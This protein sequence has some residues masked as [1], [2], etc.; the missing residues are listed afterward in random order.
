MH[1]ENS[2][3]L[4]TENGMG[5]S[6]VMN[7]ISSSM[8]LIALLG[9]IIFFGIMNKNFFAANNFI[10]IGQTLSV[11]GVI[12]IGQ[13][14]CLLTGGFD[15]SVG[16]L[17]SF[18][19]MVLASLI[20]YTEIPYALGVILVLG[21]GLGCGLVHGLVITKLKVNA[22]ITTLGFMTI[23]QGLV[24]VVSKG[25]HVLLNDEVFSFIGTKRIGGLPISIIILLTLFLVFFL[26]LRYTSFGRR[27]YCVGG[28]PKAAK[29]SGI[30]VDRVTMNAY[31]LSGL[32][33]AVA[34]V[35]LTS[36]MGAAQITA[37]ATYALDSVAG[38]VLGGILLTGGKGNIL[39]SLAG[40]A[41][42]VIL[43]NGLIMIQLPSYYQYV[44]TGAVLIFA[45]TLQNL[46]AIRNKL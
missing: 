43:Q 2:K 32:M 14:L 6:R 10:S 39:Y 36:R 45:V 44:A 46:K 15:L 16:Y 38:C 4:Q 11:V 37:G 34:G 31:M 23:Y 7:V 27:I 30:N 40:M 3:I 18:V 21:I 20:K 1:S 22:F 17:S 33:A 19:G 41:I 24:Y 9:I 12:C 13:S 29:V 28:N 5:R 26:I 35:I 42:I 25:S 8:V